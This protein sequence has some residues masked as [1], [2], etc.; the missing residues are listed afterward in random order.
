MKE[1]ATVRCHRRTVLGVLPENRPQVS[2]TRE[3]AHRAVRVLVK[4]GGVLFEGKDAV[5]TVTRRRVVEN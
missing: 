4:K 5:C 2:S 1:N 3:I